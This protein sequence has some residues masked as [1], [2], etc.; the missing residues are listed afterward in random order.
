[1]RTFLGKTGDFCLSAIERP[2]FLAIFGQLDWGFDGAWSAFQ[3]RIERHGEWG[4][5]W[6][7]GQPCDPCRPAR[8]GCAGKVCPIMERRS[9]LWPRP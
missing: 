2:H 8:A 4:S 3:A 9:D 1:M 6:E 5:P 7:G